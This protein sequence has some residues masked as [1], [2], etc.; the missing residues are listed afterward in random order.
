MAVGQLWLIRRDV[1][2]RII[3][4]TSLGPSKRRSS[5]TVGKKE[6]AEGVPSL[7]VTFE[8][9]LDFG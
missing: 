1:R 8:R 2:L 6:E 4:V 7:E 3:L 9:C 5:L